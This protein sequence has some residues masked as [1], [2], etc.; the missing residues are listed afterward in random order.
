ML[1]PSFVAFTSGVLATLCGLAAPPVSAQTAGELAALKLRTIGPANMSGRTVDIAVVEK[2][3][4]TI[5]AATSTGGVWRSKD[6]GTTWAPVFENETS[7]AVGTISIFQPNP[8]IL[9]VGTGE[10]ANRQSVSWGDGIYKSTDAGKTWTNVGLRDSRHIGRI[11]THPSNPEVV[12]VA[13]MGNLFAPNKERGLLKTTDGG[14]TWRNTLFLDEDTGVVDVAVD[15]GDP[16]IVYAASHQRRRTAYGYHGGGKGAA[17]WKSVDGGETFRK[18][19]NGLPAGEYGRIGIS[20]YRKDPKIVYV[21][22]EQGSGYNASTEYAV[23]EAGVF[24]SEDKGET[25]KHMSTWNPRPTY[26]SQIMVDPSDDQR[27]YMQNAF[28]F[29]DDGGKT[30]KAPPQT[31]HGDDRY[32]WVDPK[33]SRHLIKADDGGIGISYDRGLKWLYV[34][35]L[36]V[37][38]WYRVAADMQRPFWL[39]GGLQDNGSWAGPSAV[40]YS[41]GIL[42]DDWIRTNGGDGFFSVPEPDGS[43]VYSNGQYL[44][45]NRFNMK[46]RE[47]RVIRPWNNPLGEA[48][49]LGNWGP[50]KPLVGDFTNPA[51]WDAPIIMSPHDGKTLYA[52][53]RRL[54]RSRD[55][56]ETWQDLGDLSTGVDRRSLKV[57]GQTANERTLSLDDGVPYYATITALAESPLRK[58]WLYVGTDDGNVQ[59]SSDEGATF[60]NVASRIPGLPKSSWIAGI[61][62]SRRNAGTVYLVADNHRNGDDANYVFKSTDEGQTWTSIEGDLPKNRSLHTIREDPK[63]QNLLYLG[64]EFGLFL[65]F[66]SGKQWTELKNNM[67]RMAF[68]DLLVHPRDNDLVLATHSRGLWILDNVHA[69]QELSADVRAK[70]AHVFTIEEAEQVRLSN[71]KAHAGDMVFRGENPPNG[72]IIDYWLKEANPSSISLTIHDAAGVEIAKVEPAKA[73]GVNRVVW[74]LR[75][76]GLPAQTYRYM[77]SDRGRPLPGPLV[78]PGTYSVRL[79]VGNVLSERTFRVVD[80]RR[81][82]VSPEAR[83]AWHTALTTLAATYRTATDVIDKAKDAQEKT[84]YD[85]AVQAQARVA[86]VYANVSA[87]TGVPTADQQTQIA[88][89]S[90]FVTDLAARAKP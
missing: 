83:R 17:L 13:A 37:S 15:P 30:F 7:H 55:R 26:A 28:S 48:P 14:K 73:Q 56:G 51:N 89:L 76:P 38:Q 41:L 81:L 39:Y 10:R 60:R 36:P 50:P 77:G 87:S 68:Y 31:L 85:T 75:H 33:D 63:N 78:L 80:D 27:I 61:E 29:S 54:F 74:N 46:T 58:G 66:D 67:P 53:M 44:T 22:I 52:G 90:K 6:N 21:C 1:R 59:F 72:A 4:Y 12:W 71:P 82:T 23:Y 32:V 88:A 65:S 62:A 84:I 45:L 42:N 35:S 24:R 70:A 20:I 57:M 47:G 2:D 64:S 40:P 16:S 25:W 34:A 49:K 18:L 86:G 43:E 9:W 11:A 69:L 3:P 79:S 8:E 19:T 5:Y